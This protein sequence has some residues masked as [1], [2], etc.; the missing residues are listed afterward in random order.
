MKKGQKI[1]KTYKDRTNILHCIIEIERMINSLLNL[2]FK[3]YMSTYSN[4]SEYRED[5][6]DFSCLY[7]QNNNR[8]T[9]KKLV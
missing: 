7:P 3:I 9:K 4:K 6:L 8:H 1:N 2:V 5:P